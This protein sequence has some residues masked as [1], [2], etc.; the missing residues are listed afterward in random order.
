MTFFLRSRVLF[1]S[2]RSVSHINIL[3]RLLFQAGAY[4]YILLCASYGHLENVAEET[5]RNGSNGKY[6]G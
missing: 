4:M 3:E 1:I 6:D 2:S 5:N